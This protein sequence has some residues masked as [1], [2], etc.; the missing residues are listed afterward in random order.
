M[1]ADLFATRGSHSLSNSSFLRGRGKQ[2]VLNP[3]RKRGVVVKETSTTWYFLTHTHTP[4][5]HPAP[6]ALARKILVWLKAMVLSDSK[7]ND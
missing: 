1:W 3:L 6:F 2:Q 4:A 7:D 5:E